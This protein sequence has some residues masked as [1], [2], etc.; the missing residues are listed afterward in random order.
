[1]SQKGTPL[2]IPQL[3]KLQIQL[4][5]LQLLWCVCK[6]SLHIQLATSF[7]KDTRVVQ[8]SN[9][10]RNYFRPML[11]CNSMYMYMYLQKFLLYFITYLQG[12]ILGI[13]VVG[14]FFSFM[15]Y[16]GTVEPCTRAQQ[17]EE[18]QEGKRIVWYHWFKKPQF[19]MVSNT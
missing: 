3:T 6:Q 18:K 11:H 9:E 1:M 8:A 5:Q 7:Y 12:A 2:T 14:L 13:I 15:F 17:K 10:P 4:L 19:Y 16:L